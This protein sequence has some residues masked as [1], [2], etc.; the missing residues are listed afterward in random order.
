MDK[1]KKL[2]T[3]YRLLVQSLKYI[4][5]PIWECFNAYVKHQALIFVLILILV[6]CAS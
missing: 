1:H 4:P 3:Q 2:K 6:Y 5:Q